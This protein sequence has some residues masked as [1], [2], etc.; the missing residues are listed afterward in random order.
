[1]IIPDTDSTTYKTGK[2]IIENSKESNFWQ[3]T[4]NSSEMFYDPLITGYAFIVWTRLPVWVTNQFNNFAALTQKNFAGF[5]GFSDLEI[6]TAG[7][8]A[9]FTTNELHIAQNMGAKPNSFNIKMA[10][11]SGSPM[12]AMWQYWVSG[13]RDPETGV[14]TYPS[15]S[16][17]KLDYSLKNHTG[18]LMYIVTRPDADNVDMNNIEFAAYFT[19][20][21]P[22]RINMGHWNFTKGSQETPIEIEQPLS[23]IVHWGP[24][25]TKKAKTLLKSNIGFKFLHENDWNPDGTENGN[26]NGVSRSPITNGGLG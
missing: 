9:G 25:V 1:M 10:E 16:S 4:Y 12:T 8:T 22:K 14:A 6:N 13:I 7:F 5:D 17:P 2:S 11:F 15:L 23:A 20:V 18:E 21:M 24:K 19:C 3:G 26:K